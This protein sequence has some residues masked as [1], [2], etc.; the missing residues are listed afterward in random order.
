MRY[1]LFAATLL[2]ASPTYALPECFIKEYEVGAPL[3]E[4]SEPLERNG[5]SSV[6]TGC[7]D[8]HRYSSRKCEDPPGSSTNGIIRSRWDSG[9]HIKTYL[10]TKS[11]WSNQEYTCSENLELKDQNNTGDVASF[12]P[13]PQMIQFWQRKNGD[14]AYFKRTCGPLSIVEITAYR[15]CTFEERLGIKPASEHEEFKCK[16]QDNIVSHTNFILID[17]SGQKFKLY[18]YGGRIFPSFFMADAYGWDPGNGKTL[19]SC[20]SEK[21]NQSYTETWRI[22]DTN[23]EVSLTTVTEYQARREI[24]KQPSL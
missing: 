6:N 14:V 10:S 13:L 20:S 19:E 23:T 11:F 21:K 22:G 1:L 15:Y 4:S 2:A 9:K 17:R 7:S 12:V 18:R 16:L 24:I 3:P 8:S 5:N